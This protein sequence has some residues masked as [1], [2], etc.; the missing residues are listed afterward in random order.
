MSVAE[1]RTTTRRQPHRSVHGDARSDASPA[2]DQRECGRD[3]SVASIQ[4]GAGLAGYSASKAGL[5]LYIQTLAFEYA[6][7][8]IRANR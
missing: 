2:Q 6:R 8:G 1:W 4:V 3:L 5:S 7:E